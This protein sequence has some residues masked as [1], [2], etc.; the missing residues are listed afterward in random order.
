MAQTNHFEVTLVRSGAGRS[1]RQRRTLAGLGLKRLQQT[2]YLNDSPAI[3]GM[4]YKVVH[5]VTVKPVTGERPPSARQK[6]AARVEATA[7]NS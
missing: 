6:A 3:R 2:V 4:L 5:L 1:D 7:A